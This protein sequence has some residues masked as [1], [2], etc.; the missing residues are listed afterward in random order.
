MM[1]HRGKISAM[2]GYRGAS[3][4]P[5]IAAMAHSVNNQS[6]NDTEVGDRSSRSRSRSPQA[7][8]PSTSPREGEKLTEWDKERRRKELNRVSIGKGMRFTEH[9]RV[10]MTK[11]MEELKGTCRSNLRNWCFM[12]K[13]LVLKTR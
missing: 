13:M 7:T 11:T 6:L 3:Y 10:R 1:R 4:S 9:L 5:K 12:W 8:V 2:A